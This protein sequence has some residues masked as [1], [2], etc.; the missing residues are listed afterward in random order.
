LEREKALLKEFRSQD[1]FLSCG[2]GD[3]SHPA[4]II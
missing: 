2:E 1:F 4:G 3:P